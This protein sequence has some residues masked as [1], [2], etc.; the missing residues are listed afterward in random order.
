MPTPATRVL[1]EGPDIDELLTRVRSTH[2]SGAR[3]V[4]ADKVRSGG[5]AGF[6]ARER[7]AVE[8]E[9]EPELTPG[10]PVI[11]LAA[12]V[13]AADAGDTAQTSAATGDPASAADARTF[14]ALLSDLTRTPASAAAPRLRPADAALA[15]RMLAAPSPSPALVRSPLAAP[16]PSPAPVGSLLARL[17]ALGVP[18]GVAELVEVGG[19]G[20]LVDSLAQALAGRLAAV[21]PPPTGPG[22][23]LAIVGDGPTAYDVARGVARSMR[24][25]PRAALLVAPTPMGTDVAPERLLSGPAQ[26]RRRRTEAGVLDVAQVVAVDVPFDAGSAAWGREVVE[27]LGASSVW[28]VVDATRKPGDVLDHVAALGRVDA[29]VARGTAATRDPAS[30]LGV[31]LHCRLPTALLEGRPGTAAA[32]AALLVERLGSRA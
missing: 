12:A 20:G 14:A 29:V 7:Y 10:P 1:L 6:F 13:D 16:S 24:L 3:I 17:L 2:G 25:D 23:V 31:A 8:V 15:G 26:A 22:Q 28:A 18:R 9:V 11:D 32:W 21:P 4:S 19:S 27:A 30:V 5:V